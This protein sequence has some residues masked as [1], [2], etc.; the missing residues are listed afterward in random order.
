MPFWCHQMPINITI[1]SKTW[2]A[3]NIQ[4]LKSVAMRFLTSGISQ[5]VALVENTRVGDQEYGSA[6]RDAH[7]FTAQSLSLIPFFWWASKKA[8]PFAILLGRSVGEGTHL[9][10]VGITEAAETDCQLCSRYVFGTPQRQLPSRFIRE[11][12]AQLFESLPESMV[13]D[14]ITV[15]KQGAFII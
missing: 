1:G 5:Q 15:R 9:C 2:S 10:Y 14:Q 13:C 3:G 7:V 11:I 12:P 8:S 6:G 4:E